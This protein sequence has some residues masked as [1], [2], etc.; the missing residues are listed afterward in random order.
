MEISIK[1]K[2]KRQKG[3]KRVAQIVNLWTRGSALSFDNLHE[4]S[5]QYSETLL[6]KTALSALARCTK[7]NPGPG[8]FQA[9]GAINRAAFNA[10]QKEKSFADEHLMRLRIITVKGELATAGDFLE[11]FIGD[12]EPDNADELDAFSW[13][14][15]GLIAGQD[16]L[17]ESF[18]RLCAESKLDTL[19]EGRRFALLAVK[20][21]VVRAEDENEFLF[22][23]MFPDKKRSAKADR[24]LASISPVWEAWTQDLPAARLL[25]QF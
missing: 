20:L 18:A 19:V 25:P 3:M 10:Q 12:S 11:F 22:W 2:K 17:H 9:F 24:W 16:R 5:Q 1:D 6:Q 23:L 15:D 14:A 21:K 13:T 4:L 8:T 7:R